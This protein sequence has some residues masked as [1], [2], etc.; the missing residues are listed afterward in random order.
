MTPGGKI[1]HAAKGYLSAEDL[2]SEITFAKDLFSEM[3][4]SPGSVNVVVKR[5]HRDRI[6]ELG[7]D[8]KQIEAAQSNNPFML[9]NLAMESG[10]LFSGKTRKAELTAN[11][12]SI[13]HPMIG[14][15]KLER[16]PT[17]LVGKEKSAFVSTRS[18]GVTPAKRSKNPDD[19]SGSDSNK[20]QPSVDHEELIKKLMNQR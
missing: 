16:D 15:Q 11:A 7:Y 1:F 6:E 9:T 13:K 14:Y 12:F 20:A 4:D 3:E 2:L 8:E 19:H 10:D 18:D 17:I 5:A